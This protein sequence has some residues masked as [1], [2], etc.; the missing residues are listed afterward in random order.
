MV[1]V[2]S[3]GSAKGFAEYA[4][5]HFDNEAFCKVVRALYCMYER[6]LLAAEDEQPGYYKREGVIC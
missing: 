4:C 1:E 5:K 2:D 6:D 3:R